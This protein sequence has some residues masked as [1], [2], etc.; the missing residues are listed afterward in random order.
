MH[1]PP[2]LCTSCK[3]QHAVG[4]P[5]AW[6]PVWTRKLAPKQPSQG[7]VLLR[8]IDLDKA[9]DGRWKVEWYPVVCN[10]G[11]GTFKYYFGGQPNPYW[12]LSCH[13]AWSPLQSLHIIDVPCL[14]STALQ[15]RLPLLSGAC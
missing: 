3:R 2:C 1:V 11:S 7:A 10:V 4:I 14:L 15:C 6:R 5:S 13:Q 8:S 12:C 9:G